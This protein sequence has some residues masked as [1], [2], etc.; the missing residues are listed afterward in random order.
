MGS[1]F[2]MKAVMNERGGA[3]GLIYPTTFAHEKVVVQP[4]ISQHLSSDHTTFSFT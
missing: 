1:D 3:G 4:R 2:K